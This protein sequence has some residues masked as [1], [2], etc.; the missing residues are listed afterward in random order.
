MK[1]KL[2]KYPQP[3]ALWIKRQ[4][5]KAFEAFLVNINIHIKARQTTARRSFD[6][7]SYIP[8]I[9]RSFACAARHPIT[10]FSATHSA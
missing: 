5:D 4:P 1:L 7:Q 8:L 2:A 3:T 10:K 9:E 6:V